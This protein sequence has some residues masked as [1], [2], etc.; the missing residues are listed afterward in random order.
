MRRELIAYEDPKSHVSELFR[1]LRTNVQFMNSNK[2]LRTLLVTST[3]PNE[4]KSWIASNL[5]IT[6]AQANKRVL[7]IDADM[8]KCSLHRIFRV[9][10]CPGLS[11]Y[12]AR[13]G[14]N[15]ADTNLGKFVRETEVPNLYLLPAGNIP[16]NPSE[17]LASS[18]MTALLNELKREFDLM[19]IDGTPSKLVTD[20][21]V[22]SRIVDSTIIVTGHNMVKKDDLSKVIRDIQNV[23]GR[24]AGIVY[25]KKPVSGK[26]ISETYYYTFDTMKVDNKSR[27]EME[28][29]QKRQ[30]Q[31]N[32]ANDMIKRDRNPNESK[33]AA[34]QYQT[35]QENQHSHS[36]Q[37]PQNQQQR[38][39]HQQ[40]RP[41]Q[42]TNINQNSSINTNNTN[43]NMNHGQIQTNLP[44]QEKLPEDRAA[45]MLKQFNDYL[46]KEKENRDKRNF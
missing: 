41:Q 37:R 12:L 19:I 28:F 42:N 20:A 4:G 40:Q 44:Q 45:E 46:Q 6:F 2:K 21:V 8:R 16:P 43:T 30:A 1:T 34:Q 33:N 18:R 7:L 3:I 11:N 14:E 31:R 36:Q 23:G 5:A 9:A 35:R 25:N 29:E 38:P 10:S 39:Q 26:K 13:V 17:L 24:I 32:R 15:N 22:L 27:Q